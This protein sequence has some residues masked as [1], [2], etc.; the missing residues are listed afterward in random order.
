MGTSEFY[1]KQYELKDELRSRLKKVFAGNNCRVKDV[2]RRD[3]GFLAIVLVDSIP[4]LRDRESF[5][6]DFLK[7]KQPGRI[8]FGRDPNQLKDA[9]IVTEDYS[10]ATYTMEV[11]YRVD[12]H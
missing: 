11:S 9:I 2:I 7:D 12:R 3:E 8:Q 6:N 4:L 10:G 5:Y 1:H